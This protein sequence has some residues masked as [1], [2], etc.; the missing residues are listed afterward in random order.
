MGGDKSCRHVGQAVRLP[1][2]RRELKK[3]SHLLCEGCNPPLTSRIDAAAL[4]SWDK[5]A[6]ATDL[7]V[8]VS[9]GFVGCFSDGHFSLHLQAHP[10][11]FVGLQ[12]ASKTF[13]CEPCNMD[14]PINVRP[15]VENARQD[16]CDAVEEIAAKKRRQ[17][18]NQIRA[19]QTTLSPITT[20]NGSANNLLDL[21]THADTPPMPRGALTL[22]KKSSNDAEGHV[23]GNGVAL[24]DMPLRTKARDDKMRRRMLKTAMKREPMQE[25]SIPPM[26][27]E[28]SGELPNTVLGFTNLGNTCYFNASM[29]ALLTATHYFPEHTHIEDVLETKNTPITTTFTML[30]ETVKKR[31]RKALAG[32][33][34]SDRRG[35]SKSGRSRSGSS[36]VLTVAPL[37]KEMRNKFSQFRGHYQQDAHELFTSFLW[38]IDEEMDP[39][40]PVSETPNGSVTNSSC[41]T[42]NSSELPD[43]DED[44]SRRNGTWS[45]EDTTDSEQ[46]EEG[47]QE[48]EEDGSESDAE[49]EETKQIFVKT[50][51]GETISMQVPKSATVKEVQHLLAKRL[52]LNEEDMM[53]DASKVETRA[54]LSSR[55]SAVLHARAEKRKMYSRLNFTRNLFGGALTTAVTCNACGKRTEIVEDA[56]HL[57]VSVPDGHHRELTTT[58][59]LDD[60]VR[61]TQLLVEANNGYDCEKCSRQPKTR[62]VAGRFMRKKRLGSNAEPEMEVVLRDAS[63]QLFVSALPRVLVVHIKRLARSRK[64]T[65]HISFAEKLD[66]TPYVSET[67]RQGGGDAKN[68]SLCYELI[69]VVVHMGN[70]RSGHYV[71]YVSRSR[72][73]EALLLARAR[74]RLA[75]EEGAAEVTTPRSGDG[76][77]RTWYYVSDTVVKRVSFE[78]V[79]QCEAYMLFYQRRPKAASKTPTSSPTAETERSPTETTL[80]KTQG[81]ATSV[82]LAP[83]VSFC[84]TKNELGSRERE[85]SAGYIM[86][87]DAPTDA[88]V[89]NTDE[90]EVEEKQWREKL[91]DQRSAVGNAEETCVFLLDDLLAAIFQEMQVRSENTALFT[92][93]ARQMCSTIGRQQILKPQSS[94]HS[95]SLS[96]STT[97]LLFVRRLLNFLE[98]RV[99]RAGLELQRFPSSEAIASLSGKRK[100]IGAGRTGVETL[101]EWCIPVEHVSVFLQQLLFK[102]LVSAIPS[103]IAF[104]MAVN[105]EALGMKTHSQTRVALS[106][107]QQF[108]QKAVLTA[109]EELETS[110]RPPSSCIFQTEVPLCKVTFAGALK[111]P[112]SGPEQELLTC[113]LEEIPP[114]ATEM[115]RRAPGQ[116]A[117][118]TTLKSTQRAISRKVRLLMAPPPRLGSRWK[119]VRHKL[120]IPVAG[121]TITA[122]ADKELTIATNRTTETI[123]ENED[124]LD[125]AALSNIFSLG[126]PRQLSAQEL[127]RRNDLL[128]QLERE[129]A[130]SRRRATGTVI[131]S[132]SVTESDEASRSDQD[133]QAYVAANSIVTTG[134]VSPT[135]PQHSDHKSR[136]ARDQ[137]S[138]FELERDTLS[139]AV[140]DGN[141]HE[142]ERLSAM[143]SPIKR[144]RASVVPETPGRPIQTASTLAPLPQLDSS[145]LA[146]GV[147]AVVRGVE[148]RGP[149]RNPSRNSRLQLHNYSA[150]FDSV[151][152]RDIDV[153][154]GQLPFSPVRTTAREPDVGKEDSYRLPVIPNVSP[155]KASPH[156]KHVAFKVQN[157]LDNERTAAS[158]SPK[159][160]VRQRP[161]AK[162]KQQVWE[163]TTRS[164]PR[165]RNHFASNTN[166]RKIQRYEDEH[167]TS[168]PMAPRRNVITNSEYED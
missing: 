29:Q 136:R 159:A 35:R 7:L 110:D 117:K 114:H 140:S 64:I 74:S 145:R 102:G 82:F 131:A 135:R 99:D 97:T 89:E 115:D 165:A 119:T 2:F 10:K 65:Q 26:D 155:I 13:W 132:M 53:L 63:M 9:C 149:R 111:P 80:F 100:L 123:A 79:L 141:T 56:F 81:R 44:S 71:A 54:T 134:L 98:K 168:Q 121:A 67:L 14:I 58:D 34:P 101:N 118:K 167:S 76:P 25:I 103:A 18:R 166:F 83:R 107:L 40:L 73:R 91:D 148:K 122:E 30:H 108:V 157:D 138:K 139:F 142:Q 105:H 137:R 59:C 85:L 124:M 57:S 48:T 12:L 112:E 51:T 39:P 69:A 27:T 104:V 96:A 22:E 4:Q 128:A 41:S 46:T 113:Y 55:P 19:P 75:S 93:S 36:S 72:R 84:G 15:K 133:F 156:R 158:I 150:A 163:A 106:H 130:R 52:N 33:S 28:I 31:A 125:A 92:T 68:H 151:D 50:E 11:H 88:A 160:H 126:T 8:C 66:M 86:S 38:A 32:E 146:V 16:F 87:S 127:A 45:E 147:S 3:R 43:D 144:P 78:Q 154:R 21:E 95:R 129:A 62:S 109:E 1:E 152:D 42:A 5:H 60:F 49:Q 61:E 23:N 20:P 90:E 17:L 116:V 164:P 143:C 6:E 120:I 47:E 162:T 77:S 37:L 70:K 94:Q 24:L 153:Q 161:S